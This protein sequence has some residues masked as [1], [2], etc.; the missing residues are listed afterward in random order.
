MGQLLNKGQVEKMSKSLKNT[1]SIGE[2]LDKYSADTFR[3]A[4][5]QSNYRNIMEY[6]DSMMETALFTNTKFNAFKASC[7]SYLNGNTRSNN[8]NIDSEKVQK[9]LVESKL[10]VEECLRDDFDTAKVM[11]VLSNLTKT[12]NLILSSTSISN[13]KITYQSSHVDVI[14][15]IY[16]F[17]E[18][19]FKTFGMRQ[20]EQHSIN[21]DLECLV[22]DLLKL[23]MDLRAEASSTKNKYL[24]KVCD[25]LRDTLKSNG[26]DIKD[27]SDK[28]S[29]SFNKN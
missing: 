27:Y 24:F 20:D 6:S 9:T 8:Q 21:N 10:R 2:M 12:A 26:I 5:V 14:G 11:T 19:I 29:W 18:S 15:P 7:E 3:M 16:K 4:C 22:E 23:R 13:D 1:I 28:S 17:T 25:R